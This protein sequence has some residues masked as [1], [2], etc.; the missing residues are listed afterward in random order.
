L[1]RLPGVASAPEASLKPR[2]ARR[3]WSHVV[4]GLF[5]GASGRSVDRM[6]R[7]SGDGWTVPPP[8]SL[9][10][11][12][13]TIPE[14]AHS[15]SSSPLQSAALAV[16]GLAGWRFMVRHTA[17][18]PANP[19]WFAD[20]CFSP[21][22]GEAR[23]AAPPL[24][25]VVYTFWF[26]PPMSGDR[27]EAFAQLEAG[28]GDG[29]RVVLVTAEN[30]MA[31]EVEGC[32]FHPA[33]VAGLWDDVDDADATSAA[34][35]AAPRNA[36]GLSAI[37]RSDYLRGYFMH[38]HG[39]GYHDVKPPGAGTWDAYFALLG[40]YGRAS[41]DIW[42]LGPR[43]TR[44]GDVGCCERFAAEALALDHPWERLDGST[45]AS[46]LERGGCSGPVGPLCRAVMEA[47][48]EL[49]TNGI[50]IMRA[51]T[52]LTAGW[53][54]SVSRRLDEVWFGPD[55]GD[56]T[57]KKWDARA[58]AWRREAGLTPEVDWDEGDDGVGPLQRH[59][60][61]SARC[62]SYHENGYPLEWAEVHGMSLGPW[63]YRYKEHVAGGMP[64]WGSGSYRG[65]ESED[66]LLPSDI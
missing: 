52:P 17:T 62:C 22:V 7:G 29:V 18:H 30:L 46:V 38:H 11:A 50:Y 24:K 28:L 20:P 14:R 1:T 6:R 53:H 4:V 54:G 13:P 8:T 45:A 66:V 43:E 51:R 15:H 34:A 44:T 36:G 37:H 47:Y 9:P 60:A 25:P 57:G 55:P 5:I 23:A 31:F 41:E 3:G 33:A 49:D 63:Q 26:G 59:G 48:A 21:L 12:F 56:P 35:S 2:V 19:P 40:S 16:A 42:M 61:P 58:I 39:G 65:E 64:R 27:A 32:P 10:T